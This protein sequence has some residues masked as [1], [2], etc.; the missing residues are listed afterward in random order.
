MS[1]RLVKHVVATGTALCGVSTALAQ[2]TTTTANPLSNLLSGGSTV[3][4]GLLAVLAFVFLKFF[5]G[6][7]H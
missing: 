4:L 3:A 1:E 5:R 6:G 7:H 2:T